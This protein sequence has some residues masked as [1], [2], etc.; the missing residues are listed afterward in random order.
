L[1]TAPD[2]PPLHHPA[3]LDLKG[4]ERSTLGQLG[5]MPVDVDELIIRYGLIGSDKT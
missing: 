2:E 4:K 1:H 3:E 5:N